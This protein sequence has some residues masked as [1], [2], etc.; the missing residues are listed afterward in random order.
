MIHGSP[1]TLAE[2]GEQEGPSRRRQ[3]ERVLEE[4]CN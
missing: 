4:N 2:G 3:R 1:T